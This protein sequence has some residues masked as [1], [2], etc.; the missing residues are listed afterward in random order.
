[1]K[2]SF[3]TIHQNGKEILVMDYSG[4]KEQAMI[5][6]VSEIRNAVLTANTPVR[7]LV[8]FDERTFVTPQFMR[9][10]EKAS[11]DI[12]HLIADVAFTGMNKAKEFIL[13]GYNLTSNKNYQSFDTREEALDYL[14]RSAKY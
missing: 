1:M 3:N 13:K 9:H 8:I 12:I 11:E 6:L 4:L 5:D 14:C 10:V 7:I 2:R